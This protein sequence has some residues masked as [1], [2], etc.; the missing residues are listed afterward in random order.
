MKINTEID[1][2][3][4]F[5]FKSP[6]SGSTNIELTPLGVSFTRRK[7]NNNEDIKNES[8]RKLYN[9]IPYI[10]NV[11]IQCINHEVIGTDLD[12]NKSFSINDPIRR[13]DMRRFL[14]EKGIEP[15]SK[16]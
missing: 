3:K 1:E 6:Y 2:V 14:K 7:N 12:L 13:E 5:N 4:Y 11:L 8:G 9:S 16:R 10:G 15:I